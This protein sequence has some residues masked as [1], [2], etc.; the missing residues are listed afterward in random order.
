MSLLHLNPLLKICFRDPRTGYL[1]TT[2]GPRICSVLSLSKSCSHSLKERR[3][4][5][6]PLSCCLYAPRTT[7]HGLRLVPNFWGFELSR[8]CPPRFCSSQTR[9]SPDTAHLGHW[10]VR[11]EAVCR[12]LLRLVGGAEPDDVWG[13]NPGVSGVKEPDRPLPGEGSQTSK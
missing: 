8:L 11:S 4:T 3:Q 13:I 12:A 2:S 10:A 7:H 6:S 1:L 9:A 5:F